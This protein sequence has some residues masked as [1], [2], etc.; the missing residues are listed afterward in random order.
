MGSMLVGGG[1]LQR[2]PDGFA[3]AA[4]ELCTELDLGSVLR[5]SGLFMLMLMAMLVG[6]PAALSTAVVTV[7]VDVVDVLAASADSGWPLAGA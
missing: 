7:D 3:S 6:T 4:G 1:M 2:R 5:L